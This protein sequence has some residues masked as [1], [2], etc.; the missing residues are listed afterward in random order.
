MKKKICYIDMDGVLCDFYGAIQKHPE[1]DK[2]SKS[3][4]DM[5]PGVFNNLDPMPGAIEAF[6]LLFEMFDVYILS[7][8]P[9]RNPDAWIHK[10]D[11]IEKYIPKAKR[12]L[13][14]N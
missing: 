5:M 7:T 9:W 8:P 1:K 13:I 4:Y 14:S 10:K 11:W 6:E 12:R 3:T 2:Y